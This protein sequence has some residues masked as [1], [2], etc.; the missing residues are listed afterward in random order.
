M[1]H[2]GFAIQNT[3]MSTAIIGRMVLQRHYLLSA[4]LLTSLS[5]FAQLR[6]LRWNIFSTRTL[7]AFWVIP[8]WF[9][10][11]CRQN[12]YLNSKLMLRWGSHLKA[13]YDYRSH[14]DKRK[15]SRSGYKRS[16]GKL[17]VSHVTHVLWSN[18]EVKLENSSYY[19]ILP[20]FTFKKS[21]SINF[22]NQRPTTGKKVK[23]K[24]IKFWHL[25]TLKLNMLLMPNDLKN[26]MVILVFSV[27]R[28]KRQKSHLNI[29]RHHLA[30]CRRNKFHFWGSKI[31]IDL[32]FGMVIENH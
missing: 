22:K 11:F 19:T 27:G 17:W 16:H 31:D 21:K 15:R 32:N 1:A 24:K 3:F 14:T 5:T 13:C 30:L 4:I 12:G 18:L 7:L 29:W 10:E 2:S 20:K 6:T 25:K 8:N 26:P 23:V 28:I 9:P